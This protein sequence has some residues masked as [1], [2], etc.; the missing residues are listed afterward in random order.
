MEKNKIFG[1]K[2]EKKS[3]PSLSLLSKVFIEE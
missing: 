3:G 1:L 2:R